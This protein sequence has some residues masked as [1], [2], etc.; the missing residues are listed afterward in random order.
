MIDRNLTICDIANADPEDDRPVEQL[1]TVIA[2]IAPHLNIE[3]CDVA[4]DAAHET[5]FA[6][7][8][9]PEQGGLMVDLPVSYSDLRAAILS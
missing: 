3:V 2:E 9:D 4:Y 6:H 5:Y 7:L 1:I 8:Y